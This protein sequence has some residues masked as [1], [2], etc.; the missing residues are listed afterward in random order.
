ML[1]RKLTTGP[2]E[3]YGPPSFTDSPIPRVGLNVNGGFDG[4]PS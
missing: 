2:A 3:V 1:N 4:A